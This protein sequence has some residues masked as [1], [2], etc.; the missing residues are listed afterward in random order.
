[1]Q[2]DDFTLDRLLDSLMLVEWL[3]NG[4]RHATL[5]VPC[6]EGEALEILPHQFQWNSSRAMH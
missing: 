3:E 2:K 5:A 4:E 1:M 6:G